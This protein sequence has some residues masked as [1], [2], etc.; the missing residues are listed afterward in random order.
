MAFRAN[1]ATQAQGLLSS[2]QQAVFVKQ[3]AQVAA[4][5]LTGTVTANQVFQIVDNLRS[6]L[7]I[8]AQVAAI[9]GIA[10]YAQAQFNDATYDVA[11][12]FTNMVN[13]INAVV[14]WVV[15]NFPKDTGGF[16]Q[17]Y[18]L[19]ADGSRTPVTFTPAQTAG[20]TAA[21]NAV[22]GSIA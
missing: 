1:T 17:A 6:P 4:Q 14:N 9:P 13:T 3:S 10:A 19:A 21:I 11:T 15:T 2:M 20:L 7:Q 5:L 22:I 16:A 18:T 8:F 12:E